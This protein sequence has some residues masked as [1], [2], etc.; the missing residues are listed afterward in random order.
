MSATIQMTSKIRNIFFNMKALLVPILRVL[1]AWATQRFVRVAVFGQGIGL[2]EWES[3][4]T[5]TYV[6]SNPCLKMVSDPSEANVLAIHGPITTLSW[7]MLQAFLLKARFDVRF[8]AVGSEIEINSEGFIV[9]PDGEL[10]SIK[11]QAI[12]P[13]HPPTPLELI[14]AIKTVMELPRV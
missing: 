11:V 8:L 6:K 9:S 14:A 1:D 4:S 10:S 12:L 7:P 5:A 2:A 13:G 3:L